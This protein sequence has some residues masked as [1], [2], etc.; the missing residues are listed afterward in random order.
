MSKDDG[1]NNTINN[2]GS[3]NLSNYN[4]TKNYKTIESLK[5]PEA[6]EEDSKFF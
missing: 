1:I 4:K 6:K 5:N 2:L 3:I